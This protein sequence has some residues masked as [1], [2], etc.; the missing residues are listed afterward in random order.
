MVV[1]SAKNIPSSRICLAIQGLL[2]TLILAFLDF[3]AFFLL[4]FSWLFGQG[5]PQNPW[6]R[7]QKRLKEI[8]ESKER[9]IRVTGEAPS[10]QS[11]EM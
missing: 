2:L 10:N 3:L 5:N 8:Q 11:E 4:R 6:K 9:G 1:K 7:K